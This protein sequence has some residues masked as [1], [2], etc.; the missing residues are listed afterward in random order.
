MSLCENQRLAGLV[1]S[2]IRAMTLACTQVQGINLAQGVCDTGVPP[3]V[4]DAAKQAMDHGFNTY[5][6][7]DGLAELRQA[8]AQ[9]MGTFNHMTVNSE[10]EVTVS[11]GATGAFHCVCMGLLQPGDEVILFEPYYGYHLSTILAVEAVPRIVSL[12]EPDWFLSMEVL[13]DAITDRTK[14]IVVNTPGNPSGKV[15]TTQELEEIGAIARRHDLFIF[16][17]EIYEYFVYDNLAH[18]SLASLPDMA[19]RTVTISGY[20][21]TFGITGWRIGHAVSAPRWASMIGAMNDLVY[22]CA[23]APLQYGVAVG[24]QTLGEEFYQELQRSFQCKRDQ[25]CQVLQDIG[26][27]PTI[28]QGAYYVLADVRRLPGRTGKERAMYLLEKTGVAGVPG[29]AF[30]Q[31]DHGAR[32]IRFSFAKTNVDLD[33]ACERLQ[34]LG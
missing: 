9:R 26:L 3:V 1:Q 27:S 34:R 31:G 16:T 17:D 25:F 22:V 19:D 15:F 32:Y 13:E 29:E 21:K 18:V 11:A 4:V 8:L 12:Q 2:E 30:F 6:R 33:M 14:A 20:S 23:P 7:Y 28:P 5:T 24:I 10:T